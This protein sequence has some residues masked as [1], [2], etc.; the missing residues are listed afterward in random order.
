MSA[1]MNA[2]RVQVTR[3]SFSPTLRGCA[4]PPIED[5]ETE[6]KVSEEVEEESELQPPDLVQS[7]HLLLSRLDP[8]QIDR[9]RPCEEQDPWVHPEEQEEQHARQCV[10]GS[11]ALQPPG[12]TRSGRRV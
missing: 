12:M 3:R 5:P 1:T 2:T 11:G 7:V 10:P 8:G 9:D 6:R 4:S